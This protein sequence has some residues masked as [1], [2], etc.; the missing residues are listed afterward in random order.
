[1]EISSLFTLQA[2]VQTLISQHDK[3][4][5]FKLLSAIEIL[6]K[7]D[8]HMIRAHSVA[9]LDRWNSKGTWCTAHDEWR[10]LMETGSDQALSTAMAGTGEHSNRLRRS[11]P[12]VGLLCQERRRELLIEAGLTPA[13]PDTVERVAALLAAGLI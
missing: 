6:S 11:A 5:R 1:M 2:R 8:F 4:D 9:N 3:L 10:I 13:S 12:Y 7:F